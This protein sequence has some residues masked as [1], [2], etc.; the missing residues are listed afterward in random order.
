MSVLVFR[1]DT[2]D[3]FGPGKQPRM[4]RLEA[5][6]FSASWVQRGAMDVLIRPDGW[7]PTAG[8]NANHGITPRQCELFGVRPKIAM[9]MFMDM[10]RSASEIATW[11]IQFHANIIDIELKRVAAMPPEWKANTLLRTCIGKE[12]SRILNN[13]KLM[14]I[15]DAWNAIEVDPIPNKLDASIQLLKFVH[16]KKEQK[17]E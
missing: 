4:M 13:G 1:T 7:V 10:V 2:T 17:H 5:K 9:A 14:K 16:D 11:M 15:E 6:L 12:T 8:A 3:F